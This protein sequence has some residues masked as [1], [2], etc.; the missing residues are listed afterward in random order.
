[1]RPPE[2]ASAQKAQVAL[3]SFALFLAMGGILWYGGRQVVS[4][5]LTNGELAQFLLYLVMLAMPVRML[6]WLV[7]LFSRATASGRRMFQI[8]DQ[9]YTR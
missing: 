2:V 1:M 3:L 9:V 7:I 8:V 6:G 4:G 5:V